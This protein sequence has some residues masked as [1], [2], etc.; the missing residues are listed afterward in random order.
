MF[1]FKPLPT[2]ASLFIT[3]SEQIE[4]FHV[5]CKSVLLI[6]LAAGFI[7]HLSMSDCFSRRQ[8][9]SIKKNLMVFLLSFGNL[10]EAKSGYLFS[11]LV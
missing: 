7:K 4:L 11:G 6:E 5:P 9:V 10:I 2:I 8:T 1:K 3:T